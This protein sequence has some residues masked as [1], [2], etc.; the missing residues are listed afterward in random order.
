[1]TL[2]SADVIRPTGFSQC[3]TAASWLLLETETEINALLLLSSF[4]IDRR[5]P[6]GFFFCMAV[7]SDFC[8]TRELG[9]KPLGDMSY[10]RLV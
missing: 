7:E 4:E 8:T 9:S 6:V 10:V 5:L 3:G 2:V 1:M